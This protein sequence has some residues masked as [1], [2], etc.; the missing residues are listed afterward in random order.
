M[1][2]M[3]ISSFESFFFSGKS[4]KE[5]GGGSKGRASSWNGF[6]CGQVQDEAKEK[7]VTWAEDLVEIIEVS[8]APTPPPWPLVK[9]PWWERCFACFCCCYEAD[10]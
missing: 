2:F 8:P 7:E 4:R 10:Y 5:E 3:R 6:K 1:A 9:I